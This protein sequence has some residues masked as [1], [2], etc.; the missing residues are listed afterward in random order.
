MHGLHAYDVFDVAA[1]HG[2]VLAWQ[3]PG[4][5]VLTIVVVTLTVF[6]S[7]T[8]AYRATA[9]ESQTVFATGVNV[10]LTPFVTRSRVPLKALDTEMWHVAGVEAAATSAPSVAD[11]ET[12]S[13]NPTAVVAEARTGTSSSKSTSGLATT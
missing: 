2:V 10:P 6:R 4:G 3:L 8:T 12:I 1:A 7:D 11:A 13:K 9:A 5:A